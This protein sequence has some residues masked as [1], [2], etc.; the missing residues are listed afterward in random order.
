[1]SEKITKKLKIKKKYDFLM[2]LNI[3]YKNK[4]FN[5]RS[6]EEMAFLAGKL[7]AAYVFHDFYKRW[8]CFKK[9]FL[10]FKSR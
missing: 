3:F 5:L 8:R 1:M 6:S 10:F 7:Y 4:K 9:I 2:S